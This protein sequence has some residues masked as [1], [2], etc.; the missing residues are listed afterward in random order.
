MIRKDARAF[1]LVAAAEQSLRED[2]RFMR[3][4][5]KPE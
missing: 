2:I 3:E 5:F 1:D 4:E